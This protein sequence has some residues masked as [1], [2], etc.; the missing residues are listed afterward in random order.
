MSQRGGKPENGGG[1]R[2]VCRGQG[3]DEKTW[4]LDFKMDEDRLVNSR[5]W[6]DSWQITRNKNRASVYNHMRLNPV[7]SLNELG[8]ESSLGL[9]QGNAVLLEARFCTGEAREARAG[10]SALRTVQEAHTTSHHTCTAR[11]RTHFGL[12]LLNSSNCCGS[13]WEWQSRKL[14]VGKRGGL[15]ECFQ[16]RLSHSSQVTFVLKSIDGS[17]SGSF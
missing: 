9:L 1:R 16:W 15:G 6:E 5:N 4:L 11:V 13:F 10:I 17:I 3:G 14:R 12:H 2:Q 7:K 8:G